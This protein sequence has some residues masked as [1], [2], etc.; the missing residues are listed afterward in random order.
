MYM[1]VSVCI[2][3]SVNVCVGVY[4]WKCQCLSQYVY[5]HVSVSVCMHVCVFKS[6]M[7][8]Y[9]YAC[10]GKRIC[11]CLGLPQVRYAKLPLSVLPSATYITS[12][13][14]S[15]ARIKCVIY[16]ECLQYI[17]R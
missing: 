11:K 1:S 14:A 8:S 6:L 10:T 7:S 17:P 2:H 13:L 5:M 16:M 4:A 9:M 12:L 3:A 15:I